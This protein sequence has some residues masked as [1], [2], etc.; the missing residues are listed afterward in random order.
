MCH[1]SLVFVCVFACVDFVRSYFFGI[2]QNITT[3]EKRVLCFCLS[4]N[5]TEMERR[6]LV[7]F[8]RFLIWFECCALRVWV[9]W[10]V[11]MGATNIEQIGRAGGGRWC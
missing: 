8:R 5:G 9:V 4:S 7:W 1:L 3:V 2:Q 6:Y 11:W 10:G